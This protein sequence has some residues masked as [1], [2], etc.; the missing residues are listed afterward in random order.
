M[1]ILSDT[2]G[3]RERTPMNSATITM[4]AT[5]LRFKALRLGVL[6]TRR[7]IILD[8]RTKLKLGFFPPGMLGYSPVDRPTW[9]V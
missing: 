8:I 4:I 7:D 2:I 9:H 3:T 1:G 6:T 5:F